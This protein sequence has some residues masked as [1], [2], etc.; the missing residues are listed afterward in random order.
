[1]NIE[2]YLVSKNLLR[3]ADS[4]EKYL[5]EKCLMGN[6]IICDCLDGGSCINPILII[7]NTSYDIGFDGII[8][9]NTFQKSNRDYIFLSGFYTKKPVVIVIN[10]EDIYYWG[11]V[12]EIKSEN[13]WKLGLQY[14]SETATISI[15]LTDYC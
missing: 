2:E 8:T 9:I 15:E 6:N 4:F 3:K 11:E 7:S 5:L 13:L 1:M 10:I 12:Y 14:L